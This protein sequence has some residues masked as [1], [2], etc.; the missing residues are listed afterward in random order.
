MFLAAC[1]EVNEMHARFLT[2]LVAATISLAL[3]WSVIAGD[4]TL[5]DPKLTPGVATDL[6]A[7]QI[8]GKKWGH[9]RRF[10]TEAMKR[11]VF[12]SYGLTGNDDDSWCHLDE[13]GRRFEIDHLVSREL[14]GKDAVKNLWPQCYSGKFNATN[15]DRLENRLHKEVCNGNLSL[16]RAQSL[17]RSD[18]V[19]TYR[20]YFGEPE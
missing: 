16:K 13:H 6:T 19:A 2:A 14:G 7:K 17:I 12:K 4:L 20:R 11:E 8:C 15:K 10:V 5:P 18:W 1:R 3:G 9:D